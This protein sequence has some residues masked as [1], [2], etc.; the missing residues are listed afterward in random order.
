[1]SEG[2]E[3]WRAGDLAAAALDLATW[4]IEA[5]LDSECRDDPAL[6]AEVKRLL[7]A[8]A[9][10][11]GFLERSP[12]RTDAAAAPDLGDRLGAY[13]LV[14]LFGEGGSSRVFLAHRA[15]D[16]YQSRVAVKVIRPG[17]GGAGLLHRFRRERQILARFDHPNIARLLDGGTTLEGLPYFVLEPVDGDPIDVHSDAARLGIEARLE[18]LLTVCSA[19][20]YAHQRQVVHRDLKP[21]NI[22]VTAAGEVKLLDFGIAKLLTP[23]TVSEPLLTAPFER[24]LTPRY[25]S[26]EQLRGEPV[27]TATDTYALGL[28]LFELLVGRPAFE[29]EGRSLDELLRRRTDGPPALSRVFAALDPETAHR[30]AETRGSSPG[31]LRRHLEGDLDSIVAKALRSD[32]GE[33]YATVEQLA[34]DLRHHLRGLPVAAREGTWRYHGAKFLRRHRWAVATT[35]L[36]SMLT[37]AFLIST[38]VQASRLEAQRAYAEQQLEVAVEERLRA[39][40][41]QELMM[42]IFEA[43]DPADAGN[44]ELTARELLD[45]AVPKVHRQLEND[46]EIAPAVLTK[47]G[48]LYRDLG[49]LESAERYLGEAL[50]LQQGAS[51]ASPELLETRVQVGLLRQAQGRYDEAR[52]LFEQAVNDGAGH[53]GEDHPGVEIARLRLAQLLYEVREVD[54][55][56]AL[57]R[58]L[59]IS[60]SGPDGDPI[61]LPTTLALLGNLQTLRGEHAEAAANLERAIALRTETLGPRHN[62]VAESLN[63]L[64]VVRSQAGDA[65]GAAEAMERA[66]DISREALG[67]RHPMTVTLM[68]NLAMALRNLDVLEPAEALAREALEARRAG[69]GHGLHR[70]HSHL[71]LASILLARDDPRA[72]APHF[73]EAERECLAAVPQ[74]PLCGFARL[75]LARSAAA[76]GHD[77]QAR[78]L[79]TEVLASWRPVV[80]DD[81][82]LVR[83]TETFL[84]G[85]PSGGR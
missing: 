37:V 47:I 33:R 15:D 56:E 11:D 67:D 79:A 63:D 8:D 19:V 5:L 49:D 32:P 77:G 38:L 18:L 85:L 24:L 74:H 30:L 50:E 31:S 20:A 51:G 57:A 34:D 70:S 76:R 41:F 14:G 80:G 83:E 26:P 53:L 13:E 65:A 44:R 73:E 75:G 4:E 27:T 17:R 52:A 46:P 40:R 84:A 23:D 66:L 39:T 6:K 62:L 43:A 81:H 69:V 2:R 60:F 3:R 7:A 25:A 48:D 16:E 42:G 22:L 28:V 54:E 64:A 59:V 55:A 61:E 1:V 82:R 21:A 78:N 58:R 9:R 68:A 36:G 10:A 35:L 71:I 72:A 29:V 45:R 12:V